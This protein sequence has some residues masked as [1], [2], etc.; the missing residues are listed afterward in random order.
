[1][2]VSLADQVLNSEVASTLSASYRAAEDTAQ[3]CEL[4]DLFFI[5]KIYVIAKNG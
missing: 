1:M 3:F 2:N 5:V 4:M